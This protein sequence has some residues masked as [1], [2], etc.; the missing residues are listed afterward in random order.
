MTLIMIFF[1]EFSFWNFSERQDHGLVESSNKCCN[2]I[3]YGLVSGGKY[4]SKLKFI[5]ISQVPVTGAGNGNL[6][7]SQKGPR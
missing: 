7:Y 6:T 2:L 1:V 4:T 3:L 5:I